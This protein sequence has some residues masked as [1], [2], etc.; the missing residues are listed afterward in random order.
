MC[1]EGLPVQSNDDMAEGSPIDERKGDSCDWP[2]QV[3]FLSC[4]D[5]ISLQ[6]IIA[7]AILYVTES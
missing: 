5:A 2:Y 3:S 6:D 1:K 7:L 4:L